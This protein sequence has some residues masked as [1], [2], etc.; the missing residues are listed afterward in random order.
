MASVA[1]SFLGPKCLAM[2]AGNPNGQL[3]VHI[4]SKHLQ[5]LDC[6]AAGEVAA[7][8]GCAGLDLTVRPEGHVQPHSVETDLP[9]AIADIKNGG[10]KCVLITTAVENAANERDRTVLQTAA[11]EG[12]TH[13]RSNWFSYHAKKSMQDS[14]NNYG[15]EI[16]ELS[17]LNKDL[18]L[19]GCYQNHA[20]KRVGA[21]LWEVAKLLETADKRHF[22]VQYD[23]RHAVVEGGLSWENGLRLVKGQIKTIVLKDF[24]WKRADGKWTVVN[25]PIGEGMVDFKTYFELL[26][27][28]RIKVPVIL[29][30]EYPLGGAE[31]GSTKLNIPKKEVF[32]AMRKDL[33]KIQELWANV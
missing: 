31:N 5:F 22:G 8:L 2:K 30:L 28:Y 19:V 14:L 9:K 4:F 15:N 21:S 26:K 33:N 32:E 16:R 10:S 25:T 17:L 24:K 1:I 23:I 13:Y 6:K 11:Q 27:Q 12:I 3:P 7:E 20:G 29:H 18:G